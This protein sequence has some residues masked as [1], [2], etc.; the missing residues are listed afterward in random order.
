MRAAEPVVAGAVFLRRARAFPGV[1]TVFILTRF[2]LSP[3]RP[4]EPCLTGS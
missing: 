1:S 4:A 2:L 3:D